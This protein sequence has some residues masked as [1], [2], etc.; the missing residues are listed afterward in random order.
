MWLL[1]LWP[2]AWVLFCNCL[3]KAGQG[4]R[5]RIYSHGKGKVSRSENSLTGSV[6]ST[7][8]WGDGGGCGQRQPKLAVGDLSSKGTHPR[9]LEALG[10]R[11]SESPAWR[12]C[13]LGPLPRGIDMAGCPADTKTRSVPE[14]P[15]PKDS[16][17][18]MQA[19]PGWA[20]VPLPP[21]VVDSPKGLHQGLVTG[22][23]RITCPG[24]HCKACWY[25]GSP[26][27]EAWLGGGFTLHGEGV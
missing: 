27:L 11:E 19:L 24:P 8:A 13:G 18:C 1:P 3:G 20:C 15:V 2:W 12:T 5:C 17:H 16:R 25:T 22:R 14:E 26:L 10:R 9:T 6:R 4:C 21:W 23:T 7:R